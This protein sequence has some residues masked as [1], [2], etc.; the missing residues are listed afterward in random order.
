MPTQITNRIAEMRR[1]RRMTQQQLA[2]ALG[3]S[4]QQ[5][6]EWERGV[7]LPRVDTAIEIARVLGCKVED[8]F[9]S[10]PVL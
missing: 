5:L 9:V 6:S 10:Q 8:I 2:H 4:R 7:K 3:A 1:A